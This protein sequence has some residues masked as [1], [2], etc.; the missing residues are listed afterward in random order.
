M[1]NFHFRMEPLLELRR[2]RRDECRAA[3]AEALRVDDAL[4]KQLDVLGREIDA[5]REFC[6]RA[7]APGNVNIER[8]VEARRYDLVT[9]AQQQNIIQ[10]RQSV[11]AEIQRRRQALIEADREVRVL[12]KLR[13]RQAEQHRRD[14]ELQEAKR[15][16]EVASQ[17][18]FRK[19]QLA[20]DD[21]AWSTEQGAGRNRPRSLPG[22][23]RSGSAPR[24]LLEEASP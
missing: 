1:A 20:A 2:A 6:R 12:E 14:E 4:Q 19:M 15:L 18:S 23:P 5:L 16:D 13:Q 10:Q 22:H 3:L 9:Q 11:T 7:V 17:Q 24:S 8:L 21:G